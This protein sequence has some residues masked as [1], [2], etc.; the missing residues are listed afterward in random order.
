MR[1]ILGL[2]DDSPIATAV[3][4][5]AATIAQ[6]N[7][8]ELDLLAFVESD[9][10]TDRII[11]ALDGS[12]P[13]WQ[14]RLS[15]RPIRSGLA[16][17]LA[18]ESVAA[19]ILGASSSG[20]KPDGL[21]HIARMIA[22]TSARPLVLVPPFAAPLVGDDLEFLLPLDGHRR[23]TESVMLAVEELFAPIGT[24]VPL[25]VFGQATIP[26]FVSSDEDRAV[27]AA[28]F[29]AQ[30]MVP[31]A[32]EATAPRLRLGEAGDEIMAYI[33]RQDADAVILC[34]KQR[35]E[36]GRAEVVRRILTDGRTVVVLVPV[37]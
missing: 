34:W 20:D 16:A 23:T 35:L 26:M 6:G 7:A 28:E 12:S 37:R 36:A 18:D 14:P 31:I 4:A 1:R 15:T 2:V 17:E 25:H 33:T 11:P 32:Q 27:I 21:G 8:L 9:D 19:V 5:T 3:A 24:V 22:T 30:H 10:V 13:P 29:A